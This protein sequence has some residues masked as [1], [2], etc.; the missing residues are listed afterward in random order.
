MSKHLVDGRRAGH[1]WSGLAGPARAT[2]S[3]PTR[4]P[5]KLVLFLTA[6]SGM[7]PVMGD[8]AHAST[9]RETDDR[10]RAHGALGARQQQDVLFREELAGSWI[11][12]RH[13]TFTHCTLHFTDDKGHLDVRHEARRRLLPDWRDR[14]TWACGPTAPPRRRSEKACGDEA[15]YAR[16]SRCT[17]SASPSTWTGS[18]AARAAPSAFS[19]SGQGRSRSTAPRHAARRRRGGRRAAPVRVPH[20]HLPELRRCELESGGRVRDLRSTAT[21]TSEG[22]RIQTC[23][24]AASGD[25]TINV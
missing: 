20:G 22:D 2:S 21:S 12:K 3:S 8:A 25:C 14:Q 6:G 10:R 19:Q 23:I 11:E 7:T 1:R 16:G 18:R 13:R 4:T 9:R 24:S 5:E 17:W 15:G